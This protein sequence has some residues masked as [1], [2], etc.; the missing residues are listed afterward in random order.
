[1]CYDEFITEQPLGYC[2]YCKQ[3]VYPSEGHIYIEGVGY[4]HYDPD[5]RLKNC[6]FP[7]Y[8]E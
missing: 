2:V 3:E 7:E 1:M 6:Y 4:F 5:N 8:D